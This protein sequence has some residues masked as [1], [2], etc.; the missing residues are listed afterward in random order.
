M[1]DNHQTR[2]FSYLLSFLFLL[3]IMIFVK[4][5]LKTPAS[6]TIYDADGLEKE[7]G[8]SPIVEQENLTGRLTKIYAPNNQY[9]D[10]YADAPRRGSL[11]ANQPS[12][13]TVDYLDHD[14]ELLQFVRNTN[15]SWV[16]VHD[17]V[18]NQEYWVSYE[19]TLPQV[20]KVNWDN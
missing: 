14:V 13:N 18:A 15:G 2:V 7:G 6:S 20:P 4:D 9:Y 19:A 3:I 5:L 16:Q 11:S 8:I 1:S 10:I 12:G 17:F